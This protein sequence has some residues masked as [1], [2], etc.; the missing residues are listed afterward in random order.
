MHKFIIT[1]ILAHKS[2]FCSIII[3]SGFELFAPFGDDTIGINWAILILHIIILLLFLIAMDCGYIRFSFS[4]SF[5]SRP[6]TVDNSRLDDDVSAE[7]QRVL[8]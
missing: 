5:L 1:Y 6:I 4:L 2:K 3:S 8:I 7:R